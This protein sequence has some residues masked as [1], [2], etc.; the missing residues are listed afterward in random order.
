MA[1]LVDVHELSARSLS[2]S[3]TPNATQRTTLIVAGCYIIIIGVLWYALSLC[4]SLLYITELP[5]N[6][7]LQACA[8]F[9]LYQCVVP[10]PGFFLS[11]T[12]VLLRVPSTS[13]SVQVSAP[14]CKPVVLI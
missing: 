6:E 13:L 5:M 4:L 2:S 8:V 1:V 10:T 11:L 14:V 7:S 9:E 12:M 3:L